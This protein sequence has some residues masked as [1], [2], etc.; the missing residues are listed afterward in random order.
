[1]IPLTR[2]E[3]YMAAIV[4][5]FKGGNR[6]MVPTKPLTREEAYLDAI[7]KKSAG[8]TPGKIPVKP[9]TRREMYLNEIYKNVNSG[10]GGEG[11][12]EVIPSANGRAF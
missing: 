12:G 8:E 9:F 5:F 4:N 11:T 2:T 7:V 1:M 3:L 6:T 10:G